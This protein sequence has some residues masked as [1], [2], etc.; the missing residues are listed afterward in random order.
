MSAAIHYASV[1]YMSLLQH[2]GAIYFKSSVP[3]P[4]GS[5]RDLLN[6]PL[7]KSKFPTASTILDMMQSWLAPLIALVLWGLLVSGMYTR[8]WYTFC[9]F[10]LQGMYGLRS[11]VSIVIRRLATLKDVARMVNA[12]NTTTGTKE[13]NFL[14]SKMISLTIDLIGVF[15]GSVLSP[16]S[17]LF[18]GSVFNSRQLAAHIVIIST[19]AGITMT[20]TNVHLHIKFNKSRKKSRMQAKKKKKNSAR[21]PRT[22]DFTSS[23]SLY[24]NSVS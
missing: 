3:Q 12:K 23:V 1:W 2:R 5:N 11:F 17:L 4:Q 24:A 8:G 21:G 19:P 18:L 13:D 14:K 10:S 20:I 15:S 9:M 22:S 7:T 16:A 6:I